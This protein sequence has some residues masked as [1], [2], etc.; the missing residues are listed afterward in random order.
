MVLVPGQF[1][2]RWK[3]GSFERKQDLLC[4][5][6]RD[7]FWASVGMVMGVVYSGKSVGM[8]F[9]KLEVGGIKTL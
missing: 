6:K 8:G 9:G 5:I 1:G 7:W 2:Q 3:G 4:A